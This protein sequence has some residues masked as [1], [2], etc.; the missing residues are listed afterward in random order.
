[1]DLVGAIFDA[2]GVPALVEWH[3]DPQPFVMIVEGVETSLTGTVHDRST[4]WERTDSGKRERIERCVITITPDAAGAYG[5]VADVQSKA[6]FRVDGIEYSVDDAEGRGI[7]SATD[8]LI[9]VHLVRTRP[10]NTAGRNR[11]RK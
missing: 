10:I 5:G 4:H 1:M 6:R 9:D 7:Q 2:Q 11:E 8:Q 3:G